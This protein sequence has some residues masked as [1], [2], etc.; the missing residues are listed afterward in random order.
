MA[1]SVAWSQPD[2]VMILLTE[3]KSEGRKGHKE[4][5]TEGGC[6]EVWQSVSR[7]EPWMVLGDVHGDVQPVTDC[8]ASRPGIKS[9]GCVYCFWTPKNGGTFP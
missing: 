4:A 2:A 5:A 3:D 6:S 7:D 9:H 1:K 8:K